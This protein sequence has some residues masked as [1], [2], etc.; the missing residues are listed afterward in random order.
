[1]NETW[2]YCTECRHLHVCMRVY[3][4]GRHGGRW[5][6]VPLDGEA[7]GLLIGHE[8]TLE[9]GTGTH[10]DVDVFLRSADCDQLD[11]SCKTTSST[12]AAEPRCKHPNHRITRLIV[13][14]YAYQQKQVQSGAHLLSGSK[15]AELLQDWAFHSAHSSSDCCKLQRNNDTVSQTRL[16]FA[17]ALFLLIT[18][19]LHYMFARLGVWFLQNHQF[20]INNWC[21]GS[22]EKDTFY[23]YAD[24]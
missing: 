4:L 22:N 12:H 19:C 6:K 10:G 20:Y 15:L 16:Q 23:K 3:L 17:P 14:W 24:I 21:L 13:T 18:H 5:I 7:G 2:C 1:M 8:G 11:T 9:Q